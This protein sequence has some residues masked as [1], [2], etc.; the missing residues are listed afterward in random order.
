MK[1]ILQVLTKVPISTIVV[2]LLVLIVLVF[3]N[4]LTSISEW[5]MRVS[6]EEIK[7][8][9]SI[10]VTDIKTMGKLKVLKRFVGG[11]LELPSDTKE[12]EKDREN[13][14][15][16]Y[17]WEGSAEFAVDLEK[18]IRDTNVVDRCVVLHMPNIEI[19]NIR[20][21]AVDGSR[22]VIKKAKLG[23]NKEADA[24]LG[25]ISQLIG[26]KIR[27]EVDTPENFK[28]AKA[29]A[30]YLLSS[31]IMAARPDVSVKFDWGN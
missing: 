25:S 27:K 19:E 20:E 11:F 22:C 7:G 6:K 21:L 12:N 14:R 29:Q 31:M 16:V 8:N 3:A 15:V 2:A 10:V 30:E 5:W 23:H 18:V 26:K 1:K 24:I 13:F 28:K 17:Q 9:E 4:P